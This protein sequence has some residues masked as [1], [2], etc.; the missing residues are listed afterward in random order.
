MRIFP[1]KDRERELLTELRHQLEGEVREGVHV[2]DLINPLQSYWKTVQPLPVSDDEIGFWLVGRGHHYFLVG[3]LTGVEG[4]EE[5]SLI[6]KDTGIHYSP[7][8]HTLKGEFK[9]NRRFKIPTSEA[10]AKQAFEG[11]AEQC[12]SYAA[13]E[14]ITYWYLYVMYI[15]PEDPDSGRKIPRLRVYKLEWTQEE[16]DAWKVELLQRRDA[17]VR[18]RE[19]G[20]PSD[21]PLCKQYVCHTYRKGIGKVPICKWWDI[22]KPKGRHPDNPVEEV[23]D[24]RSISEGQGSKIPAGDGQKD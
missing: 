9:T 20:D 5:V 22:C 15:V 7:D 24:D 4:G 6:D 17:L 13:F 3:A 10:Q 19:T 16:V 1:D 14:G 12:L 21:L 8:L 2:S 23:V 11:Y 18:A